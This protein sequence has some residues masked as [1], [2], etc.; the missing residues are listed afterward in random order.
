MRDEKDEN[1][2]F[3]IENNST[4]WEASKWKSEVSTKLLLQKFDINL[5]F[6][7]SKN[8]VQN[9]KLENPFIFFCKERLSDYF[10]SLL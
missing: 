1:S 8:Y 2:D 3:F 9:Y 6:Q 10:K 7:P 4:S 5:K